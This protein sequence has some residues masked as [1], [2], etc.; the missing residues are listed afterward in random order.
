VPNTIRVVIRHLL[1]AILFWH[2]MHCVFPTAFPPPDPM[3]WIRPYGELSFCELMHT[4][5]G[6][7]PSYVVAL[8]VSEVAAGALLLFARTT[9]LGAILGT[10]GLINIV[11]LKVGYACRIDGLVTPA[12]G[13]LAGLYLLA[14]DRKRILGFFVLDRPTESSHIDDVPPELHRRILVGFVLV[15][16]YPGIYIPARAYARM[17]RIAPTAGM[18]DV[19]TF[20][21]DGVSEPV[22]YEN[23]NRWQMLA[24]ARHG[25]SAAVRTIGD[26]G[27]MLPATVFTV[28]PS[29]G[30]KYRF[31]GTVNNQRIVAAL[32][33]LDPRDYRFSLEY[34]IGGQVKKRRWG[35]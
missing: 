22:L 11:L 33:K 14:Q 9:T 26:E 3:L 5:V 28:T 8:G 6:F 13:M 10:F 15:L 23:P 20:A 31:E 7:A 34:V 17:K 35:F 18:Y 4:W 30:D 1:A 25:D 27:F 32:R 2:G 21:R 12:I 24:I 19:E 16:L 29:G